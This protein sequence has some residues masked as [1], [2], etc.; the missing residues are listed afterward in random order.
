MADAPP[1]ETLGQMWP[2]EFL[3][4]SLAE[5]IMVGHAEGMPEF[6]FST[7]QIAH[8]IAYLKTLEE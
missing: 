7:D 1:F 2:V 8:F 4:E 5:G 3:E 6:V